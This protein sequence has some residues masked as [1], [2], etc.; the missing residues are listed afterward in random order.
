MR[1]YSWIMIY[2]PSYDYIE[3]GEFVSIDRPINTV[4]T[5]ILD[6]TLYI[7]PAN[8]YWIPLL[9][10]AIKVLLS[11]RNWQAAPPDVL[12]EMTGQI[13]DFISNFKPVDK[14]LGFAPL[15][16]LPTVSF[17]GAFPGFDF[18]PA[19]YLTYYNNLGF[20]LYTFN[21][22]Q[23][24]LKNE[25]LTEIKFVD[26]AFQPAGIHILE[27]SVSVSSTLGQALITIIDCADT[28]HAYI[29]AYA[30]NLSD[31]EPN[32]MT[33]KQINIS[34]TEDMLAVLFIG[35][36]PVVCGGA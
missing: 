2:L 10:G 33:I 16:W 9:I 14:Y 21:L 17:T 30:W 5:D 8:E 12:A 29:A 36:G 32:G 18:Q 28:P 31:V 6:D 7:S 1:E 25:I 23:P 35:D 11:D 3:F 4:P 13:D 27:L 26:Q 24:V 20:K 15:R 34:T 22:I 19:Q